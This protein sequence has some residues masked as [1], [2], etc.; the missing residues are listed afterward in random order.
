VYVKWRQRENHEIESIP[1]HADIVRCVRSRRTKYNHRAP[2]TILHEE[3]M[4]GKN[5]DDKSKR[6][7]R[8]EEEILSKRLAS[9]Q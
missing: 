1:G 2:K 6:W 7:I 4:A 3:I 8:D 9:S 5:E